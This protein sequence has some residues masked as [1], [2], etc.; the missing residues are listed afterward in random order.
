MWYT[1]V[2]FSFKSQFFISFTQ[3]GQPQM[4][5]MLLQEPLQTQTPVSSQSVN[6]AVWE[7]FLLGLFLVWSDIS[8]FSLTFLLVERRWLLSPE[9][10]VLV[11]PRPAIMGLS[12][13]FGRFSPCTAVLIWHTIAAPDRLHDVEAKQTVTSLINEALWFMH[14]TGRGAWWKQKMCIQQSW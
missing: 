4:E 5:M 1:G 13:T 9:K 6:T 2:N 12:L 7:M 8:C 11:A 10:S 14:F 3:H